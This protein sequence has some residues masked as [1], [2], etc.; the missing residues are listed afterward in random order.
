[1]NIVFKALKIIDSKQKKKLSFLFFLSLIAS[2]LELLGIGI[3]L[4]FLT[5][6][7]SD[8]Q[9]INL[10]FLT[11]GGK[12]N[13]NLFDIKI[14]FLSAIVIVFFSKNVYLFFQL[15]YQSKIIYEVAENLSSKLFK[16]YLNLNIIDFKLKNTSSLIRNTTTEV[17]TFCSG[18][19][20]SFII[21]LTEIFLLLVI[22]TFLLF[23]NLKLTLIS[24]IFLTLI[25]LVIYLSLKKKFYF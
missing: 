1:M 25:S 5:S 20:N 15:K 6:L 16:I 10:S 9:I 2:F 19:L 18:Y 8:D 11:F 14:F 22:I 13:P 3:I 12:F 7:V 23:L 24:L 17:N 21:I 4:P